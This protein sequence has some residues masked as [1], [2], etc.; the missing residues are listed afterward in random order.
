MTEEVS[1]NG[2]PQRTAAEDLQRTFAPMLAELEDKEMELVNRQ[3]TVARELESISAELERLASV[4]AAMLGQAVRPTKRRRGGASTPGPSPKAGSVRTEKQQRQERVL[5]WAREQ[6]EPFSGSD[7]SEALDL[8][9]NGTGPVLAAMARA[10]LLRG[11]RNDAG[12]R[13]YVVA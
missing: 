10:G 2:T 9:L 5:A 13:V 1:D 11:D 7:V 3:N 8:P 6:A 4:K 12:H